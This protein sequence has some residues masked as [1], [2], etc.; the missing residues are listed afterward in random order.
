MPEERISFTQPSNKLLKSGNVVGLTDQIYPIT[1]S[2]VTFDEVLVKGD[3]SGELEYN[4]R[5]LKIVR[6][7]IITGLLIDMRG[8]RGPV[9]QGVKC[10][11]LD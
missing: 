5:K 3:L 4:G 1:S 7:D 10:E 9:W 11:V 8:A 2:S 6:T